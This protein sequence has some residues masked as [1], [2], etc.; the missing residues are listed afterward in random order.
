MAARFVLP[1]GMLVLSVTVLPAGLDGGPPLQWGHGIMADRFRQV[2]GLLAGITHADGAGG[3]EKRIEQHAELAHFQGACPWVRQSRDELN[4]QR[5][6]VMFF[7][8]LGD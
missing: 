7:G 6:V 4:A 5:S 2:D 8:E 1:I 3:S